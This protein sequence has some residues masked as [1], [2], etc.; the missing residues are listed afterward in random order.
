MAVTALKGLSALGNVMT[1]STRMDVISPFIVMSTSGSSQILWINARDLESNFV[2][3]IFV[4]SMMYS[5]FSR[6]WPIEAHNW[7]SSSAKRAAVRD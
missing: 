3:G 4:H 1:S 7:N 2:A 6:D 5:I